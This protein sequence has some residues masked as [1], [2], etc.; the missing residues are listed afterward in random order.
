M[1]DQISTGYTTQSLQGVDS[2]QK[3]KIKNDKTNLGKDDF[4][5]LLVTE[6]QHQDPTRPMED[7]EFIAQMAQ[8]SS[9]EQITNLNN[10]MSSMSD[11][12]VFNKAYNFLGKEIEAFNPNTKEVVRG[13]V[14]KIVMQTDGVKLIVDGKPIN[15]QDVH[16]VYPPKT[17]INT[18]AINT[19]KDFNINNDKVKDA[20]GRQESLN[21]NQA[22]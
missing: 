20:Y 15:V 6:L 17:K 10:T 1:S 19:A 3:T 22:E 5:K 2:Y 12:A 14:E 11:A 21:N 13:E 7:K 18:G 4:L 9:L 16:A 8:F